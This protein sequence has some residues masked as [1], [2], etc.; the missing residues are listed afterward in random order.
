MV[1]GFLAG[2]I[3]CCTLWALWLAGRTTN[4]WRLKLARDR[5]TG[6]SSTVTAETPGLTVKPRLAL[7]FDGVMS[8]Y[9]GGWGNGDGE[10]P[11]NPVAG[12]FTALRQYQ[13]VYELWVHSVRCRSVEGQQAITA[14]IVQHD[15]EWAAAEQLAGRTF[16]SLDIHIC[17][18]KPPA[19]IYL[20]DRGMTFDGWWPALEV[21]Q[22]FK[23][24][25]ARQ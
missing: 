4:R 25:W 11:G 2:I 24:W 6:K 20:D 12:C 9:S 21:L 17:S 23:P 10:I 13:Q 1:F 7:D 16:V 19:A 22:A 14:W 5:A 18:S 15:A 8:D 3:F